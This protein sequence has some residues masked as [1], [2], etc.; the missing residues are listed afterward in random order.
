[1]KEHELTYRFETDD[2]RYTIEKQ[3]V[4]YENDKIIETF[5][6]LL[7]VSRASLDVCT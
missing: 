7:L 1:M 3:K 6:H 2:M 5:C 4:V